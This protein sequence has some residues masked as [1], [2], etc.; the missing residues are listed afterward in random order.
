MKYYL[1]K[2]IN[3]QY[4]WFPIFFGCHCR[5]DRSFYYKTMK[6]PVCARCTGELIGLIL[7]L[8][9]SWLF[10]PNTFILLIMLIP[11]IA[12]GLIQLLSHYES[13]NLRR[14]LTG[15]LFGYALIELFIISIIRAFQF[16]F[17]IGMQMK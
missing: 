5:A 3:F 17:K 10:R 2:F 7:A 9:T 16:G 14:L 6:F 15:I 8:L 4:K 13:T 12:D 1:Y 11:L